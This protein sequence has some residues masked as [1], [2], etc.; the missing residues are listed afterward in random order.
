M[1]QYLLKKKIKFFLKFLYSIPSRS[2]ITVAVLFHYC[3][4]C[5]KQIVVIFHGFLKQY[6]NYSA[7]DENTYTPWGQLSV[8]RQIN[9]ESNSSNK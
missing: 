9:N 3:V 1:L 8:N 4:V 5:Q 6:H 7:C 2:Y